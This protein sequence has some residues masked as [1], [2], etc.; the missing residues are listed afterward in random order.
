MYGN[1]RSQDGSF[2][3]TNLMFFSEFGRIMKI[4]I[5][6]DTDTT[7]QCIDWTVAMKLQ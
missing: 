3:K 6:R 4:K 5:D 7:M 1:M 2:G